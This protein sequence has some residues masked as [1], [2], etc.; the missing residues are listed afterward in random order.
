MS[1]GRVER[2]AGGEILLAGVLDYQSG[3][4]LRR[5]GQALV[6]SGEGQ[7][8]VIDCSAVAK[9]S[10][11]GLSL[12]LSFTRDAMAAG[13]EVSIVGLPGDM[14]EI[15]RVSGLLNVLAIDDEVQGVA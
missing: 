10:S 1:E 14:R 3:P 11:V 5:A 13:R 4:A 9:S 12:L 2:G 7:R 6:R 8:L 15:A